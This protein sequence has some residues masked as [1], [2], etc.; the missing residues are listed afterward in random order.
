VG[1][2]RPGFEGSFVVLDR[3]VFTVPPREIAGVRVAETWIRGER[4]FRR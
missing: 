2:I 3:D 1:L 4:V